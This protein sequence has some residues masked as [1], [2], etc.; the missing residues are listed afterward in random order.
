[1]SWF[2]GDFGGKKGMIRI[3]KN[4]NIIS[5]DI[6]PKINFKK[7]DWTLKLNNYKNENQ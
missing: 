2:R 7:Y 4:Y 3:L 6:N 5:S 1:M